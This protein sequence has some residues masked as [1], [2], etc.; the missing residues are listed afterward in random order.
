MY[1]DG[2]FN[3][4]NIDISDKV[5]EQ[6][7]NYAKKK[8]KNMICNKYIFCK[9]NYLKIVIEMDAT[10]MTFESNSFDVVIDKGTLDAIAVK[11]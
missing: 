4:I 11:I 9:N 7:T 5:I 8:D 1:D 10:N 3:I 6:M 2:Y